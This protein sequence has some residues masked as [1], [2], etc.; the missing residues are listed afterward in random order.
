M[1]CN[2]FE[3]LNDQRFRYRIGN[4]WSPWK[5]ISSEHLSN[6][7]E[8]DKEYGGRDNWQVQWLYIYDNPGEE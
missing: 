8:L 3:R 6:P 4:F 5:L 7:H 1:C 2:K